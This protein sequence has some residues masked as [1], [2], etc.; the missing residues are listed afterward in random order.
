MTTPSLRACRSCYA[1][2]LMCRRR[3][4]RAQPAAQ[5]CAAGCS[6]SCC[7]SNRCPGRQAPADHDARLHAHDHG[8]ACRAAPQPQTRPSTGWSGEGRFR[9]CQGPRWLPAP[10][11]CGSQ[12]NALGYLPV[13]CCTASS[14]AAGAGAEAAAPPAAPPAAAALKRPPSGRTSP[15]TNEAPGVA[16][17]DAVL[18]PAIRPASQR[19]AQTH[20]TGHSKPAQLMD[21][22]RKSPGP[23]AAPLA[24]PAAGLLAAAKQVASRG[25]AADPTT[26][27]SP[28]DKAAAHLLPHRAGHMSPR[29]QTEPPPRQASP[30]EKQWQQHLPCVI[31]T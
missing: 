4:A 16:A 31:P 28:A 30:L 8:Q 7:C 10:Q 24:S 13:G 12:A 5:P 23:V 2:C 6:S 27:V 29:A 20:Q 3:L 26:P 19:Q 21:L 22:A 1:E 17:A 15:P 25:Q 18:I 14:G 11:S 9:R